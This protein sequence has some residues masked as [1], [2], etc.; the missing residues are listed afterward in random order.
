M[1]GSELLTLERWQQ[2]NPVRRWVQ[3]IARLTD[4]LI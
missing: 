3:N 1:A 4:T 2:R